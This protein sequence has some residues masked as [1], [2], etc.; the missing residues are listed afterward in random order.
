MRAAGLHIG[1]RIRLTSQ[2]YA[3]PFNEAKMIVHFS[4]AWADMRQQH[5]ALHE[6]AFEAA[7]QAGFEEVE[8][9][10]ALRSAS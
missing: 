10:V 7:K 3:I 5:D 9:N 1:Y 8:E 6:M 2:L 4:D